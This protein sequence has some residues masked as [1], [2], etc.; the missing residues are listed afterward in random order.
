MHVTALPV[1]HLLSLCLLTVACLPIRATATETPIAG[2]WISDCH[3]V[4]RDGR[5]GL[6]TRVALSPASVQARA[7]LYADPACTRPNAEAR[8]QGVVLEVR[9]EGDGR[10]A[11]EHR[12]A[13]ISLTLIDAGVAA[14]YN[15]RPDSIGC[16]LGDWQTGIA[17][18]VSGRRCTAF[19]FAAAGTVL[20]ERAWLGGESGKEQLHFGSLPLVWDADAADKRA[21]VPGPVAFRRAGAAADAP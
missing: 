6:L 20:H 11:L 21:E 9:A 13:A 19:R 17:R 16:G 8:Y 1:R 5:H 2:E 18:E 10:Y 4:G 14:Q 12:I 7:T 15:A 3:P